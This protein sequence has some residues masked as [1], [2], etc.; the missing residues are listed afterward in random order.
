MFRESSP[1]SPSYAAIV[2]DNARLSE[3]KEMYRLLNIAT[4]RRCVRLEAVLS[5]TVIMG[6]AGCVFVDHL[7]TKSQER[8][9]RLSYLLRD[10]Q[11]SAAE[12]QGTATRLTESLMRLRDQETRDYSLC[13]SERRDLQEYLICTTVGSM[14]RREPGSSRSCRAAYERARSSDPVPVLNP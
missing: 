8:A 1:E 7:L 13:E 11:F 4:K 10:Q 14:M 2:K 6:A 9:A 12:Q 5:L 3:E